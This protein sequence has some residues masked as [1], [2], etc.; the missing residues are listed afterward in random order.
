[1]GLLATPA[2][3][4]WSSSATGPVTAMSATL[5]PPTGLGATCGGILGLGSRTVRL[6]WSASVTPW[7]DGYEVRIGPSSGTY[8]ST[9]PNATSPYDAGPLSPGTYHFTVRSTSGDWRSSNA[10]DV[11]K[12]ITLVIAVYSCG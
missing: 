8:T 6:T 3:A 2:D 10:G 9:F 5:A 11:S 7:T 1:M 12:T 4:Q